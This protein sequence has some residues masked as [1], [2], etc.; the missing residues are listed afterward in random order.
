MAPR[1]VAADADAGAGVAVMD[2]ATHPRCGAPIGDSPLICDRPAGHGFPLCGVPTTTD[3]E[4]EAAHY[5][6]KFDEGNDQGRHDP[7]EVVVPPRPTAAVRRVL[8]AAVDASVGALPALVLAAL[9]VAA[10][11]I[12]H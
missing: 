10:V 11:G 4:A 7:V 3:E 6:D 12:P 5:R 8:V 9:A 1:G 2:R